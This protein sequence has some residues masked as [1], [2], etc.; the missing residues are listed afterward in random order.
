MY[1][2]TRFPWNI[3]RNVIEQKAIVDAAAII[4]FYYELAV[5]IV[6]TILFTLI[7]ARYREKKNELTQ[8]LM[9]SFLFYNLGVLFAM[10]GKLLTMYYAGDF[11]AESILIQE[12]Y[13]R[14]HSLRLTFTFVG[15]AVLYSY[16]FET[17]V[18][19]KQPNPLMKKLTIGFGIATILFSLIVY[20]PD[21]K[22]LNLP[23]FLLSFLLM[24]VVYFPFM[25]RSFSTGRRMTEPQYKQAFIA[26]GLMSLFYMLVFLNFIIDNIMLN[27]FQTRFSVFYY[28]GWGCVLMSIITGYF[29][30]IRPG[31]AKEQS[32]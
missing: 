16:K 20:S 30:Y 31:S 4:P 27:M 28:I 14:I 11:T 26:L 7:A 15:I 3:V 25:I 5:V 13:G 22:A 32:E 9:V 2:G 18:F 10:F 23:A 12:I 17:K 1:L 19:E 21:N 24:V 6:G 29:G 8:I